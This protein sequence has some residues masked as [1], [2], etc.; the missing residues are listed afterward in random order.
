MVDRAILLPLIFIAALVLCIMAAIAA[1]KG[2]AYRYP[3]N[4]RLIK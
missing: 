1:N 2:E 4:W 3:V